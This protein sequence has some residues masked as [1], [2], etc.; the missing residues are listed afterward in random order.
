MNSGDRALL[1]SLLTDQRLVA[2]ALVVKAEPVAGL[3]PFVAS[4]DFSALI[5]QASRLARHS[6]GLT[7][8]ASF[9]GVI[10][11]PDAEDADPLQ[12]P[13]V[14]LEGVVDTLDGDE[15]AR[16]VARRAYLR[17]FPSAAVTAA[18]PDFSVF[19]LEIRGGR[20]VG[21]FGRAV[22]ISSTDL[23]SLAGDGEPYN[24]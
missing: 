9:S 20:V 8:G 11:R 14:L 17:R 23:A 1:K 7:S 22:N 13:R 3:L 5:V 10:H 12:T 2:L 18:L 4:E 19:R 21:G 24:S 16:E 15:P 6:Q